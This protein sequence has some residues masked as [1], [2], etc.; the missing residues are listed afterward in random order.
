MVVNRE[1]W[2]RKGKELDDGGVEDLTGRGAESRDT[3][4]FSARP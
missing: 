3:A 4:A 1:W 2:V